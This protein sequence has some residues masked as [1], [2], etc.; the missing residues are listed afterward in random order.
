MHEHIRRP[1]PPPQKK[2]RKKNEKKKKKHPPLNSLADQGQK[3]RNQCLS[4]KPIVKPTHLA[5]SHAIHPSDMV[6]TSF[7]L[8]KILTGLVLLSG[9][10]PL[11]VFL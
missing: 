4:A 6:M 7:L 3:A 1:H 8:Y 9:D 2:K 10:L 5:C 11:G